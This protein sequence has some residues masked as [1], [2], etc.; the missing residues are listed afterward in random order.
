[1]PSLSDKL[2]SLG[3]QVGAQGLPP[4]R[5]SN[6]YQ[7]ETV[8]DGALIETPFG[9]TYMVETLYSLEHRQG[10]VGI[11]LTSSLQ[12]IAHWA[13]DPRLVEIDLNNLVFLDTET[14]GLVGGTGTYVFLVGIGRYDRDYF[15]LNQ[16]F[17]RDPLEELAHLAAVLGVLDASSALVTF[18]GK[19]FDVPLLNTRYITNGESPPFTDN[20]HL[21]LLPLARRLWRDRVPS[22]ALGY[23]EQHILGVQ[24]EEAD[25]P[26]WL[27]PS[28]YFD[29]LR[30][31]DARPLRSV[32]YHNAMDVVSMAGL[33][34]HVAN[35][36][37]G[38]LS[39]S[40]VDGIDLIAIAKLFESMGLL[41]DAVHCYSGGLACEIPEENWREAIT[42]WAL[43]E[44][45][46][47]NLEVAAELWQQAAERQDLF[48]LVELAKYAEHRLRDYEQALAWTERALS[49][50]NSTDFPLYERR[51]WLPELEH[52]RLRIQ[53]KLA[54]S[55]K[56]T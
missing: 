25:V 34:N 51:R 45:R 56:S 33:L 24:R 28:L 39:A 23:L 13:G 5:R 3:V 49:F 41:D 44:K 32:F 9:Q 15:R 50:V 18:N 20:A 29:Y 1:M 47:E 31:G 11:N 46:R 16:F 35:L 37:E 4:P 8:I 48:A 43:L 7:I 12:T 26:G 17:M 10:L 55:W 2:K 27:I 36:L 22:R 40:T 21:D 38:P 30:N 19:A 53:L 52:R 6:R 14:S 54:A 42:R